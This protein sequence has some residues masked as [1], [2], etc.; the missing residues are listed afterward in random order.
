MSEF[1]IISVDSF[2]LATP[3]AV[4]ANDNA[5]WH[6]DVWLMARTYLAWYRRYRLIDPKSLSSIAR[7]HRAVI[8]SETR[9]MVEACWRE[10]S[11]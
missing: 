8:L 11:E 1:H 4:A 2:D 6:S 3:P 10:L 7:H 5:D 9:A